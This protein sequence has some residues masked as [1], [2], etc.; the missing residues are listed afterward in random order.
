MRLRLCKTMTAAGANHPLI[1]GSICALHLGTPLI[2]CANK[3]WGDGSLAAEDDVVWTNMSVS[4]PDSL[5]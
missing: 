2:V 3:G 4:F 1:G 5:S